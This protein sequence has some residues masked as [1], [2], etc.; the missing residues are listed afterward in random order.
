MYDFFGNEPR[1]KAQLREYFLTWQRKQFRAEVDKWGYV[2]EYEFFRHAN[3]Y[4]ILR[5][6]KT[7]TYLF[8]RFNGDW[9]RAN[10]PTEHYASFDAVMD[11]ITEFYA[12][13]WSPWWPRDYLVELEN[14]LLREAE[15][16]SS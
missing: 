14:K 7:D 9:S 13:L 6:V 2:C 10:F 12:N 3:L 8:W 5:C 15:H 11:A 16:K 4:W 1:T